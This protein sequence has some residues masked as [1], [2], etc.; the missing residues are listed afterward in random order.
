[1]KGLLSDKKY[2]ASLILNIA[3]IG[4]TIAG[5]FFNE[6]YLAGR[7][8]LGGSYLILPGIILWLS[9]EVGLL[10]LLLKERDN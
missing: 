10:C 9:G 6:L 1:M 8:L 2:R 7:L 3:G 4:L 5:W